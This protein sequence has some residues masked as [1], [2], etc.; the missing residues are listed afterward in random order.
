MLF[1][2]TLAAGGCDCK[3]YSKAHAKDGTSTGQYSSTV[4]RPEWRGPAHPPSLDP[5][6]VS[7]EPNRRDSVSLHG[8]VASSRG[9]VDGDGAAQSSDAP[10]ARELLLKAQLDA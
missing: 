2:D 10:T 6:Q 9:D 5:R 8:S 7:S 3:F 4:W 1:S